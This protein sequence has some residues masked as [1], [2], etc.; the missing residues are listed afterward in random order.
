LG[1]PPAAVDVDARPTGDRVEIFTCRHQPRHGVEHVVIAAAA[2]VPYMLTA[3]DP[4]T[5][6]RFI[7]E[8]VTGTRSRSWC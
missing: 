8:T 2:I 6:M 1:E 4:A 5:V 7:D 3:A